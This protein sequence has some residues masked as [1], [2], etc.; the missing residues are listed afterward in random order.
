M[1][2]NSNSSFWMKGVSVLQV[3]GSC[4][5]KRFE[6]YDMVL[7]SDKVQARGFIGSPFRLLFVWG[8]L[9]KVKYVTPSQMYRR[10]SVDSLLSCY[11]SFCGAAV[12]SKN[13]I[14][15]CARAMF[16]TDLHSLKI[17]HPK[18]KLAFQSS[19][20]RRDVRSPG[21]VYPFSHNHGSAENYP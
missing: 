13:A 19:I 12:A 18:R 4:H 2:C 11:G 8:H 3:V 7:F 9:T 14:D 15:P 5:N 17:G 6:V 16:V 21:G 20:F 1:N 10:I